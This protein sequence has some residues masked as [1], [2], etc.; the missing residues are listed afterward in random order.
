[1]IALSNCWTSVYNYTTGNDNITLAMIECKNVIMFCNFIEGK[2]E[3]IIYN[4]G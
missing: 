2:L 3:Q 4:I 1:M